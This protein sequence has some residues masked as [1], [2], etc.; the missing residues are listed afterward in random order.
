[1]KPGDVVRLVAATPRAMVSRAYQQNL[2]IRVGSSCGIIVCIDNSRNWVTV[3]FSKG[4]MNIFPKLLE[5]V[6]D[7]EDKTVE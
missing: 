5:V 1:V 6:I 3:L 7:Y 4:K 2:R